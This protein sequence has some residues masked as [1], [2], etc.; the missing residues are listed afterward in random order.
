MRHVHADLSGTRY[1]STEEIEDVP[2][3]KGHLNKDYEKSGFQLSL[4]GAKQRGNPLQSE[5]IAT[6]RSR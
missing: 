2:A 5:E 3:L 1:C 6:L 4:R